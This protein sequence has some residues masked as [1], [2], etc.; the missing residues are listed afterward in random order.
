MSHQRATLATVHL[1]FD[2]FLLRKI[3]G[4]PAFLFLKFRVICFRINSLRK[5]PCDYRVFAG[6]LRLFCFLGSVSFGFRSWVVLLEGASS[7]KHYCRA[8]LDA[9]LV[10]ITGYTPFLTKQVCT[11]RTLRSCLLLLLVLVSGWVSLSELLFCVCY[12]VLV[13]L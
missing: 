4:L 3:F 9:G 2:L 11:T 10:T 8:Q 5:E 12:Q 7:G 6:L 13:Y 1:D